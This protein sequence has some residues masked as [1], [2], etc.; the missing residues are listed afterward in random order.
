MVPPTPDTVQKQHIPVYDLQVN[1]SGM[2]SIIHRIVTARKKE[3]HDGIDPTSIVQSNCCLRKT[4]RVPPVDE[5]GVAGDHCTFA[6]SAKDLE[7]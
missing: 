5:P 1:R 2:P 3:E 7:S 4:P 6:R